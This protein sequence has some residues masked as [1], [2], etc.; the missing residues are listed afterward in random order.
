MNGNPTGLAVA[1]VDFADESLDVQLELG[2]FGNVHPARYDD[3]QQSDRTTESGIG[4]QKCLERDQAL[5]NPLGIVQPVDAE[6]NL[7]ICQLR[8][9]LGRGGYCG[10]PGRFRL[11]RVVIDADGICADDRIPASCT[12]DE[13]IANLS[14]TQSRY[15]AAQARNKVITISECLETDRVELKQRIQYLQAPWQNLENVHCGEW[16]MKEVGEPLFQ[17]AF[18]QREGYHHQMI[19][20]DPNETSFFCCL[21]DGVREFFVHRTVAFPI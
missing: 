16:N 21:L 5:G 4:L 9:D 11:D 18:S 10:R 20:M 3:L 8:A 14:Y 12:H 15:T 7:P 1:A 19:V 13:A 6:D 2:V 17:S